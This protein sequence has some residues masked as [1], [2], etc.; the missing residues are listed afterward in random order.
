M[1]QKRP[2]F[3]KVQEEM[4]FLEGRK[5]D[6]TA[7][8]QTLHKQE[9]L[10]DIKLKQLEQDLKEIDREENE[11]KRQLQERREAAEGIVLTTEQQNEYNKIK[12]EVGLQTAVEN[13]QALERDHKLDTSSLESML[14]TN[15]K[16]LECLREEY[17]KS[18][19]DLQQRA[20]KIE[21]D[22]S[23]TVASKAQ[24]QNS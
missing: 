8:L 22:I 16:E 5:K 9:E 23:E 21:S 24:L 20:Q 14:S 11:F 18:G 19:E 10:K 13:Q 1:I 3:I 12:E 17:Q 15:K 6:G 4:S 2:D 7:E